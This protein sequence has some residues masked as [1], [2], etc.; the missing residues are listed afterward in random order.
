MVE[1]MGVDGIILRAYVE[2][3]RSKPRTNFG[4]PHHCRGVGKGMGRRGEP[5]VGHEIQR[6]KEV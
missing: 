4:I 1:T 3:E 2:Q 6:R 5:E